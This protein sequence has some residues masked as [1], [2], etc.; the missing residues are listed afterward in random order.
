[1]AL[2]LGVFLVLDSNSFYRATTM[3]SIIASSHMQN[4]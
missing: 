2:K 1:M 4:Y 3:G